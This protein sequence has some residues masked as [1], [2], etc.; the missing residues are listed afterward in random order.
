MD[1]KIKDELNFAKTE[2]DPQDNTKNFQ[3]YDKK[4]QEVYKDE[5]GAGK[6][7]E[8]FVPSSAS[9]T[10]ITTK[11]DLKRL[12]SN[13]LERPWQAAEV[14]ELLQSL[15][16]TYLKIISYFS[17]MFHIRYT[18][19]P[20]LLDKTDVITSQEYMDRYRG[21][22]EVVDGL[23]LEILV[24]EMLEEVFLR[25]ATYPYVEK[26]SNSKTVMVTL[27]PAEFCRTVLKTNYGTNLIEFN[28]EY[29]EEFTGGEQRERVLDLFPKEF[30]AGFQQYQANRTQEWLPLNPK[31]S[32]SILKNVRS[33]PP[34]INALDGILEYESAREVEQTKSQNE[35]S[36][37]LTHRIPI[38]EGRPIFDL[39]EVVSIQRAISRVTSEHEGLST[40]TTFGETELLTLQEEGKVEN[41]RI[42]QAYQTVFNS[43]GLNANLFTGDQ[44]QS[45]QASRSIDKAMVWRL[46][47]QINLF[48]N[49]SINNIYKFKPLQ[50][51]IKI[52]PITVYDELDQVKLYRENAAYGIGKIEAIVAAGVKQ[53]H[54]EDIARLEQELDLGNLLRPLQSSHT[55][56]GMVDDNS[57]GDT[58][59]NNNNNNNNNNNDDDDVADAAEDQQ[60]AEAENQRGDE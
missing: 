20:V 53:R 23:N 11:A 2:S 58:E 36:K 19:T 1:D 42:N 43:A 9:L 16:G 57:E 5:I 33:L 46:I 6:R 35:L 15:D 48:L 18:V 14:S 13:S 60:D 26:A 45:L 56:S 4:I 41:K 40:I 25:G 32:T 54:L 21:M 3:Q 24:P 51:E 47:Q 30:R 52:L 12:L 59:E 55:V 44:Q 27:L 28:Y 7:Y 17:D 37:I 49:L 39:K 50:T 10:R 38:D 22:M 29:F 34:F 31:F 8:H